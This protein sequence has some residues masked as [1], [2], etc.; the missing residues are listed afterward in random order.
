MQMMGRAMLVGLAL[1]AGAA[2]ASTAP[3]DFADLRQRGIL[4]VLVV[5]GAPAF[6]S[7]DPAGPPGFER[8][9]LDGFAR[10]HGLKVAL[11]PVLTWEELVPF[12]LERK[13]DLIA[14]GVTD[15]AARRV[16][17]DFTGE[18]FPTRDVVLTRRPHLPILTLD[19]LRQVKV[20]TIKGTSLADRVA[21]A[22][23]PPT[24]VVDDLPATGFAEALRSGRVAAV[25][26]GVEDA[27]LL[28]QQDPQLD[29]GMFLGPPQSL[30]F[31]VRKDAPALR[32]AL[33]DYLAGVRKTTWGRLV[34]KYFGADAADVLRKARGN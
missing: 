25:V 8:E 30:A 6:V 29:L 14:G 3:D 15:N 17:V 22:K 18:V 1:A 5:E 10:L 32:A 34:V 11:V 4:R 21:E 12:L 2:A 20:G 26:D 7:L 9:I 28:K 27:L 24:N 33:S 19:E 16:H 31:G 23:V 13:G